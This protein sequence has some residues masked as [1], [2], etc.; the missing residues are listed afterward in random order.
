M[1]SL[2]NEKSLFERIGGA[3]AVDTAVELFYEKILA[4]CRINHFF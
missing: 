3:K 1:E 2:S 4:D